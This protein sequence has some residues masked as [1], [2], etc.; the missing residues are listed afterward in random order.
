ME[1]I[2]DYN[3]LHEAH[4]REQER[5]LKKFPKCD[6]CREHITDDYFYNIDGLYLHDECLKAEYRVKTDDYMNE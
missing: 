1:Y 6:C 4:E 5:R 2:P 3:D